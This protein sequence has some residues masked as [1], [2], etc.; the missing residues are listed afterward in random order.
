MNRT[1]A[2]V[3]LVAFL[4]FSCNGREPFLPTD[5]SAALSKPRTEANSQPTG[6]SGHADIE[7]EFGATVV[8]QY[9][10]N[11]HV[12]P[13]GRVN[14]QFEFRAKYLGLVVRAHGRVDCVAVE[15]NKARIGGTVTHSTFEEGIPVGS[16]LTWRV[17]DNGE[18]QDSE[19]TA[20]AML[21]MP[22]GFS[23]E[24]FCATGAP[25]PYPEFPVGRGNIQVR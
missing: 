15:G 3:A 4:T 10:F 5:P 23:A 20:S 17:T 21:G 1:H 25:Y 14:G 7:F 9:S 8:D 2:A 16:E 24:L 18:G 11:A 22:P 12:N 6:A 19:D 13:Y